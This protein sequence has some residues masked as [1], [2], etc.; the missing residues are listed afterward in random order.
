MKASELR[1]KSVD[2]LNAELEVQLERQFKLRMQLATSQLGQTHQIKD[3]RQ[4]IARI[5]TILNE[6]VGNSN[7]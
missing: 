1:E 7:D 2:E 5:E 4:H 3:T 6:K